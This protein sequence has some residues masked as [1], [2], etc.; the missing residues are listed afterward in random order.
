MTKLNEKTLLQ[1]GVY[2]IVDIDSEK[3]YIGS[4]GNLNRRRSEHLSELKRNKHYCGELQKLYSEGRSLELT[5]IPLETKQEAEEMEQRLLDEFHASGVLLNKSSLARN[6]FLGVPFTEERREKLRKSTLGNKNCLGRV[7]SDEMK[8]KISD[9]NKG[10]TYCLGRTHTPEAKEKISKAHLGNTWAA[11]NVHSPETRTKI[12][13]ARKGSVFSEEHKAK[14]S[15]AK[16]KA[17]E[18]DGVVIKILKK[19]W[20]LLMYQDTL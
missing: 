13:E 18:I 14:L 11:G 2:F 17:V 4:T 12:S 10:N 20:L 16:G 5:V 1:P 8:K 19:L 15:A 3:T 6:E 9:A 7:V